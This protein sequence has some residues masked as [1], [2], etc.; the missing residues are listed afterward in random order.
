MTPHSLIRPLL[1]VGIRAVFVGVASSVA[2]PAR[3]ADCDTPLRTPSSNPDI[4]AQ[5]RIIRPETIQAALDLLRWPPDK[6][7]MIE[8]VEIRPPQL[9]ILAEG[10]VVYD[11]DGRARPTLHVAA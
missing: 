10:W 7:P 6:G 4:V 5:G 11:A 3:A 2:T 8:V 9:N 1:L